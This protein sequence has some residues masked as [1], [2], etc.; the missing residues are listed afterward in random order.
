MNNDEKMGEKWVARRLRRGPDE[1]IQYTI[2]QTKKQV[3]AGVGTGVDTERC[4]YL[5]SRVRM[6]HI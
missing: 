2:A 4:S 3:D 5:Y 1:N 6:P